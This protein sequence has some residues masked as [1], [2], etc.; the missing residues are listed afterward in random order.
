MTDLMMKDMNPGNRYE[1]IRLRGK[2]SYGLVGEYYD[3]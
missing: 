2:G 1:F 3:K